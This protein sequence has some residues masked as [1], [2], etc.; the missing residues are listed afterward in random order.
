MS[1]IFKKETGE[2]LT[3]FIR[4]YRL[5]KAKEL[6]RGTNKKIV[7]ICKETG[8]TNASYF[9]KSFREYYGCSPERFRKGVNANEDFE[10]SH[11]DIS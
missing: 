2:G 10:E 9:C 6:L 5:E 8:F 1:Y 3:H 4:A 11:P 7:Q